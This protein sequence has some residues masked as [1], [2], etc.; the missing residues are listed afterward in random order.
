MDRLR[1][2]DVIEVKHLFLPDRQA[3]LDLLGELDPADWSRPT[4]CAGWDVRDVALHLLG[5]DLGNIASRRDGVAYLRPTEEEDLGPFINRINAE[6]ITASR[7]LTPRLIRELLEFTAQPISDCMAAVDASAVEAHVSWASAQPV[8]RWLDL[9]REYM[10]RWVHQQHIRE[11]VGRPGQEEPEFVGPVVAASMFALPIAMAGQDP[12]T[13]VL[14]IDGPGGGTWTV[15]RRVGGWQLLQGVAPGTAAR[16]RIAVG[17]WWRT[18]TL[19]L[20]P[21]EALTRAS[22]DGHPALAQAA[23]RAVAIIA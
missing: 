3:L 16:L 17:D 23:L 18:V 6:W 10:E 4:V 5:V 20:S 15:A 19:G 21:E 11:A 13:L 12:G 14:E 22:I 9:A 1:E 7:R 2:P 8:A